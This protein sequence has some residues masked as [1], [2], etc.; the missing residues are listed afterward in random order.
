[1]EQK[2]R[3]G[4]V[5]I[6]NYRVDFGWLS[7]YTQRPGGM[8]T[9]TG[10]F[11]TTTGL[12]LT[13]FHVIEGSSALFIQ[14]PTL[15]KQKLKVKIVGVAPERDVAILLLPKTER[16]MVK[17]T[18]EEIPILT[19][20]DSD[21]VRPTNEVL[22]LGYPLGEQI[23][24]S[25]KGIVSGWAEGYLQIDASLNGGNSGG[26][27]LNQEGEVIGINSAVKA[28]AQGMSLIIPSNTVISLL[29]AMQK[30][31]FLLLP[32]MGFQY[33]D[34]T[35]ELIE[36]MQ[37]PLPGGMYLFRVF[38]T[39][40]FSRAGLSES[41]MVYA[42][43]GHVVDRFGEIQVPW[44][45]DKLSLQSYLNRL[46]VGQSLTFLVYRKGKRFE[47]K[48]DYLPTPRVPVS[49]HYPDFETIDYEVFGG[50]VLMNLRFNHIPLITEQ[51]PL[52]NRF[53][54]PSNQLKPKVVLVQI[55]PGSQA[56]KTNIFAVGDILQSLNRVS[57]HTLQ[58]V[59]KGLQK[60][61]DT[62]SIKTDEGEVAIFSLAKVL[63]DEPMLIETFQYRPSQLVHVGLSR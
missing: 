49:P 13:N 63:Q 9:G 28:N 11:I 47:A 24:K 42:I 21:K 1:V 40:L 45:T 17:K 33:Q 34:A 19:L 26:P 44:S 61:T 51:R 57:I 12:I 52:F 35:Q 36:Y 39:Y 41:D 2:A 48:V 6:F 31:K 30:T 62:I 3:N 15:G 14:I 60:T 46:Q 37:N 22:A 29:P 55:L 27:A 7:P 18:L 8:A 20:G 56:Q 53:Y 23:L 59:R 43:N 5:Q 38:P 50:L 58:D 16:E 4:V 10:F 25:T 32:T 54:N